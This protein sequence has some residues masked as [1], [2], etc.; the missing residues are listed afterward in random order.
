MKKIVSYFMSLTVLYLGQYSV[1]HYCTHDYFSIEG[2]WN[3][4]AGFA[5]CCRSDTYY[6]YCSNICK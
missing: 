3:R 6:Q 1:L 4:L 5:E 2:V